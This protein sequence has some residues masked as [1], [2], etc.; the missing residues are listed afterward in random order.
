METN[1]NPAV[2]WFRTKRSPSGGNRGHR[3]RS[4]SKSPKGEK[5]SSSPNK[6]SNQGNTHRPGKYIK[7]DDGSMY[8]K[9]FQGNCYKCGVWGHHQNDCPLNKISESKTGSTSKST[10]NR[11]DVPVYRGKINVLDVGDGGDEPM[12]STV[13]SSP[14]DSD[15]R[16]VSTA[17]LESLFRRL[18]ELDTRLQSFSQSLSK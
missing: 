14:S 15:S 13:I 8:V 7:L 4:R 18:E 16:E 2:N 5:R 17:S 12:P 6:S 3:S 11:G 1:Q 9:V 10:S